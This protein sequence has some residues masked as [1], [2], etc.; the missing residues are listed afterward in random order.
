MGVITVFITYPGKATDRF[1]RRY[2]L[3]EHFA[4]VRATWEPLGMKSLSG[5]FPDGDGGGFVAIAPTVF[6]DEAAM[7]EAFNSPVSKPIFDDV[8]R[9]T[10]IEPV[11]L[12]AKPAS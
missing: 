12:V 7:Q 4:L 10:D 1:D 9:F 6:R 3:S 11:R 2:W 8:K 5:F